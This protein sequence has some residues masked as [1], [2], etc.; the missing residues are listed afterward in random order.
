MIAKFVNRYIFFLL[1]L[2]AAPILAGRALAQTVC[3]DPDRPCGSFKAYEL[4]FRIP[5]A[6]V[7]RA[8]DQS[9]LFFAVILKSAKPCSVAE[10]ERLAAQGLFPHNKVFA[11]RFEC[12]AE[13]NIRY[14]TIDTKYGI[15]AAYA[16]KTPSEAKAFLARVR[17]TGRFPDAYLRRM[18]AIRVH[19]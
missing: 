14:T 18:R 13:D 8:E 11:S 1:L 4:A 16:G 9:E 10:S 7:A 12:D 2:T 17:Q 15:L 5:A 19:P 3:P 6:K